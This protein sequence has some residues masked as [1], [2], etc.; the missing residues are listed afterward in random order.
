MLLS[1]GRIRSMPQ[2]LFFRFEAFAA[3][4]W[5]IQAWEN[6]FFVLLICLLQMPNSRCGSQEWKNSPGPI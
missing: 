4:D 1:L 3:S 6:M 5:Q 2:L